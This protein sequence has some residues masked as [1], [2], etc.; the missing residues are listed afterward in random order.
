MIFIHGKCTYWYCYVDLFIWNSNPEYRKQITVVNL[1]NR[2]NDQVFNV[3]ANNIDKNRVTFHSLFYRILT[4]SSTNFIDYGTVVMNHATLRTFTIENISRKKLRLEITSSLPEEIQIYILAKKEVKPTLPLV[5][6]DALQLEDIS[7]TKNMDS[8]GTD[9]L[10]LASSLPPSVKEIR[11]SPIRAGARKASRAAVS[12]RSLAHMSGADQEG[13]PG[14]N[15]PD[16]VR[17]AAS[18]KP[19]T[20]GANAAALI[21]KENTA[22]LAAVIS[23]L[24]TSSRHALV[25]GKQ[26]TEEKFVRTQL[27]MNRNLESVL[28]DRRLIPISAVDIDMDSSEMIVL[29]FKPSG[30]NRPYIQGKPK[31]QDA[32]IFLRLLEFDRDADQAPEFTALLTSSLDQIPVRELIVRSSLCRSIMEIG[33][34]NINFGLMAKRERRFKTIIIYNRSEVPLMYSI[35]KTGSV[36]SGDLIFGEGRLGVVRGLGKREIMFT[37]VPSMPGNYFEKIIIENIQDH[38]NDQPIGL[39]A[40]IRKPSNFFVKSLELDFGAFLANEATHSMQQIIITNTTKQPRTMELRV[41]SK[42]LIFKRCFGEMFFDVAT[43]SKGHH[44]LS[45]EVEEEIEH[46]EQKLKISIRK[47]QADKAK[48]IT[49]KLG[50]LRGTEMENSAAQENESS[51]DKGSESASDVVKRPSSAPGMKL[52]ATDDGIIFSLDGRS[53]T[54]INVYLRVISDQTADDFNGDQTEICAGDILVNELKNNDVVKRVNFRILSCFD[55]ASYILAL[56]GHKT[57]FRALSNDVLPSSRPGSPRISRAPSTMLFNQGPVAVLQQPSPGGLQLIPLLLD[58]GKIEV[59]PSSSYYLTLYNAEASPLDYLIR[60]PSDSCIVLRDSSRGRLRPKESRRV[61]LSLNTAEFGRQIHSLVVID[62]THRREFEFTVTFHAL[63]ERYLQFDGLAPTGEIDFGACYLDPSQRFSKS[64]VLTVHNVANE[65]LLVAIR[66]NLVQ[67]LFIFS[68]RNLEQPLSRFVLDIQESKKLYLA[69]QPNI[70]AGG[71]RLG[72]S[73]ELVGGLKLSVLASGNVDRD[74][75]GDQETLVSQTIR[76]VAVVGESVIETSTKEFDFG[77]TK[78]METFDGHFVLTNPSPHLPLDV[79]I[80]CPDTIEI[81][82]KSLTLYGTE[83]KA[84]STTKVE[85]LFTPRTF[86][87]FESSIRLLNLHN[88]DQDCQIVI[89]AFIDPEVLSIRPLGHLKDAIAEKEYVMVSW[90]YLYLQKMGVAWNLVQSPS[91][92]DRSIEVVNVSDK[93]V[94]FSVTC[95]FAAEVQNSNLLGMENEQVVCTRVCALPGQPIC[96]RI[97]PTCPRTISASMENKLANGECVRSH[98]TLR[99]VSDETGQVLGLV[100]LFTNYACSRGTIEPSLIDLGR[101]GLLGRLDDVSFKFFIK[102]LCDAPLLYEIEDQE[103][104]DIAPPEGTA[105]TMQKKSK[106]CVPGRGQVAVSGLVK[107]KKLPNLS[108]SAQ[109]FPLLVR[110]LCNSGEKLEVL[111]KASI[112]VFQ[113]KFGR[114]V[115]G[116]LV[117]PPLISPQPLLATPCDSWFTI[118]NDSGEDARFEIA[119]ELAPEIAEVLVVEVLSRFSNS[120]LKGLITLAAGGTI[121]VKVRAAMKAESKRLSEI[122][123]NITN[124][125][126]VTFGRLRVA[127]KVPGNDEVSVREDVPLRGTIIEGPSF[128]I[129][130]KQVEIRCDNPPDSDHE[131]DDDVD[132]NANAVT[133]KPEKRRS[134]SQISVINLSAIFPLHFKVFQEVLESFPADCVRVSPLD[135]NAMG[136]VPPGESLV[137]QIELQNYY[138]SGSVDIKIH[139]QDQ[140]SISRQTETVIVTIT[141]DTRRL[142]LANSDTSL[143]DRDLVSATEELSSSLQDSGSNATGNAK[144]TQRIIIPHGLP[145]IL[146]RGCKRVPAQAPKHSE[147]NRYEVDVGQQDVGSG[148]VIK[149]LSLENDSSRP[150]RYRIRST[151][152]ETGDDTWLTLSKTEGTLEMVNTAKS[153]GEKDSK[154]EGHVHP[155]SISFHPRKCGNY[156]AYLFVENL[157]NPSDTKF[158]RVTMEVKDICTRATHGCRWWHYR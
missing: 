148:A 25:F 151:M 28:R 132:R 157:D 42:D 21:A 109:T 60:T 68:D 114:L 110:N 144:P 138:P 45:K 8:S 127:V 101:L 52:R 129:S 22:K 44:G 12:H 154:F 88:R 71:L 141:S 30:K 142:S 81:A 98:G 64:I 152:N 9:Y 126:G 19:A 105:T 113:L 2:E 1:Y 92:P 29:L 26:S 34:K 13:A 135:Q 4:P 24:E 80:Q 108:S 111:F 145:T 115:S 75:S 55:H 104:V 136:V 137:L 58:L 36:A 128:A 16:V 125:D 76:F 47:G 7:L 6:K 10:D 23:A 49:E 57:D 53:S 117:L 94:T 67:Q 17:G 140:N 155:I 73:R 143:D 86:G 50:K 146:L 69:L 20:T 89:R 133:R 91:M 79:E 61:Y 149:R 134:I 85:F 15:I 43:D 118:S 96:L 40:H 74:M 46:L 5:S 82:E 78:S 11:N 39:K 103:A 99:I 72:E 90:D 32:K 3:C 14:A 107:P 18:E 87:Y 156:C 27:L 35:K 112:S 38:D 59:H 130:E 84:A 106:L 56:E 120:K 51:N 66:S 121:E 100:K 62:R 37:F 65:Q 116:E 93:P 70:T 48:K 41:D 95:E 77:V 97:R 158:I 147:S 150:M 54:T 123:Q 122:S 33:Q 63:Q 139:A 31:K 83:S 131:S 124:A 102:N 119:A 153:A